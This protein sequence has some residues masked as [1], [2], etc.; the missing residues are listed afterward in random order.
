MSNES[1]LSPEASGANRL[2]ARRLQ[3]LN[4][5][6]GIRQRRPRGL[7]SDELRRAL[8][9]LDELI[10]DL[11]LPEETLADFISI[12]PLPGPRFFAHFA[13]HAE[14]DAALAATH[15]DKRHVLRNIKEF[16]RQ[17]RHAQFRRRYHAGENRPLL[18]A[19]GDSWF[20]FPVFL[21]DVTLQLSHD[22]LVLPL[23]SA[24]DTLKHMVYGAEATRGQ[25]YVGGLRDYG[26]DAKAFLFSG[27]GN[28]LIGIDPTG[29]PAILSYLR[30]YERG[31]SPGWYIDTPEFRRRLA[32]IEAALRHV[33]AEVAVRRPHLPVLIHG[34]DY[35]QPCPWGTEDQRHPRWTA[36]DHFLGSAARRLGIADP[37]LQR[38]IARCVIDAINDVQRRLSGGNVEGGAFAHVYHVD[39]RE[40]VPRDEWADEIHPTNEGYARVAD[41]FRAVLADIGVRAA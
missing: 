4:R 22:H 39:V 6:M 12:E 14:I 28:D 33:L 10:V 13:L 16:C 8:A 3:I 29:T 34:Y 7:S 31:R 25:R 11:S 35:A 24:G 17:R 36:R 30:P 37:A 38:A 1:L 15:H 2:P 32:F 40:A 23:A 9:S 27:G 21:R 18:I 26:H 19:D 5:D 41:R 20:H